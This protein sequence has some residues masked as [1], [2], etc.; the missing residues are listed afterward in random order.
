[1]NLLV[2]FATSPLASF[3]RTF[4]AGV[5]GWVILNA[6]SLDLHPALIIGLVSA[7]PVLISWLNPAD[8]RF[9]TVET[10]SDGTD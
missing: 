8:P 6:D 4:A 1:M 5:L 7:L 9:G 10:E 2:W 3:A